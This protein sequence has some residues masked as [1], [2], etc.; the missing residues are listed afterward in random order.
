[1]TPAAAPWSRLS[2]S[3]WSA[4]IGAHDG[5]PGRQRAEHGPRASV[6]RNEICEPQYI[7]LV[8][9]GLHVNPGRE[10]PEQRDV[11]AP[12]YGKQTAAPGTAARANGET[13]E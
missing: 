1:M 10:A 5:N 4:N 3:N 8:D 2:F 11:E 7:G 6:A 13:R 12:P 9:P